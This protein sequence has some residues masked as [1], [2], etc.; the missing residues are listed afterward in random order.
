[1][2]KLLL[3]SIMILLLVPII[4]LAQ[5]N[6]IKT[7]IAKCAAIDGD[8]ER[9]ECY[10]Q[11]ARDLDLIITTTTSDVEGSG[12][13]SCEIETNPIDDTKRVTL[14]LISGEATEETFERGEDAALFIRC[15]SNE[16]ELWIMWLNYLGSE[17]H[18]LTRVGKD[19]AVSKKWVLSTDSQGTFYP[20]NSIPFIKTL[21][22]VDKLVAQIT[23]YSE[24]PMT[25]IF[26]VRGL[27]EAIKPLQ[28]TCGWN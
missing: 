1:M 8:L 19:K 25:V 10:D 16:T 6:E 18:V 26:D 5:D 17:A 2:R 22:E 14:C 4:S 28:E 24:S 12:K 9:L 7:L 20:G 21:M 27:K 13:W 11:L 15:Q 3:V 23:P